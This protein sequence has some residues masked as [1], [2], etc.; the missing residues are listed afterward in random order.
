MEQHH[1]EL[2]KRAAAAAKKAL[3]E[4]QRL[5]LLAK[6]ALAEYDAQTIAS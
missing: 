4:E 1:Q 2:A 3:T 6:M 5:S